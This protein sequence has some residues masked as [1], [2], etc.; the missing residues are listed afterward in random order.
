MMKELY[1][2]TIGATAACS[3]RLAEGTNQSP[4]ASSVVMG[5]A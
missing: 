1:C 5:D 4:E 2:N 3:I